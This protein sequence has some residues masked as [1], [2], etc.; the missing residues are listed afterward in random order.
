MEADAI[1][2][3]VEPI[4]FGKVALTHRIQRH[5]PGDGQVLVL[6]RQHRLQRLQG[7]A[8]NI[9]LVLLL[10]PAGHLG[11]ADLALS[12]GP[13]HREHVLLTFVERHL[14]GISLLRLLRLHDHV[15][16]VPRYG[17]VCSEIE[18]PQRHLVKLSL[19]QWIVHELME[20]LHKVSLD[21]ICLALLHK[22]RLVHQSQALGVERLP[23]VQH[24]SVLV[25]TEAP[26]VFQV[27]VGLGVDLL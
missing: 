19:P 13:F 5:T 10:H 11:S 16:I 24:V 4:L 1:S 7:L 22:G 15:L 17:L 12:P 27:L 6:L 26:E 25:H 23:G 14:Q 20:Q 18:L 2:H 9:G 21:A 3:S 8:A